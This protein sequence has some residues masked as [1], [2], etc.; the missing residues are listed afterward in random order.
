VPRHEDPVVLRGEGRYTDDQNLDGHTYMVMLRSTHAHGILCGFD[1]TEARAM[2]GVLGVYTSQEL[3]EGGSGRLE[4]IRISGVSCC[5]GLSGASGVVVGE[6]W[7][8]S[9][10]QWPKRAVERACSGL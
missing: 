7:V 6:A 3:T 5:G 2:S 10:E 1:A 9:F 4:S 8:P